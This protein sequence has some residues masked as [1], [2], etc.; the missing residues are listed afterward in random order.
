V[1][2]SHQSN[3]II[4]NINTLV[5]G[6]IGERCG[7]QSNT[8]VATVEY[9]VESLEERL[10]VDKVESRSTRGANVANNQVNCAGNTANV[11]VEGTRKDLS[12][13]SQ[14]ECSAANDKVQSL[15]CTELRASDTEQT[16]RSIDHP[17]GGRL[18]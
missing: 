18:V 12:I 5:G 16:S 15:Q 13:R 1:K 6:G 9:R 3:P 11:G 8:P 17:T 2:R 7:S 10:A 4:A 14:S